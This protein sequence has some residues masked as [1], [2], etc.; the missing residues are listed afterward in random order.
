[1]W[2]DHLRE[3]HSHGMQLVTQVLAKSPNN[4]SVDS[5]EPQLNKRS[6]AVCLHT[7][8][9]KPQNNKT[10]HSPKSME[11]ENNFIKNPTNECT[12]CVLEGF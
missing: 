6:C 9:K 1:M 2:R 11:R 12:P 5:K 7:G 3:K 10:K 4:P 8:V